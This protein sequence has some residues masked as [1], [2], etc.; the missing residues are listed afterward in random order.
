MPARMKQS[1]K[2]P[3]LIF[4]TVIATG[5]CAALILAALVFAL[6]PARAGVPSAS[7]DL[8]TNQTI[9]HLRIDVTPAAM[10]ALRGYA[11]QPDTPRADR[12]EV[13]CTVREGSNVWTNVAIHLKGSLG[14]FRPV[15]AKPSFTL[16]F[17]KHDPSQLFH[18]LE[19]ISL[20]NS[21]QDP[22]RLSEKVARELY[23]RGGVPVPRAGHVTA[24]WNGRA[25]G[26]YV[27]LEGWDRRFIRRYF[28]DARGPLQEGRL[29]T[30]IDQPL[31]LAFGEP[32]EGRVSIAALL[33]A[34][35]EP[36]A[37]KRRTRLDS[38]LDLDRFTRLLALDILAWNGDGYAFHANNYRVFFDRSRERLVF[39][40]HGLD[41]T[42]ILPDAPVLASGDGLVATAVLSLPEGR[43][44]VLDRIREFRGSFFQPEAIS[45]RLSELAAPLAAAFARLTNAYEVT[46]VSDHAQAVRD[47]VQRM[48]ERLASIDQQLAGI[49]NLVPILEGQS[50]ALNGWNQ[51]TNSGSPVFLQLTNP[52]SLV[53][54][55]GTNI[56][57][58]WVT[59]VWLEGGRYRLEGRVRAIPAAPGATNH[60]TAGLRVRSSR[61]RSLGLDW[62][63]D[64]RRRAAH[65]PGSESGNLAYA[66]LPPAAGSNWT[67][68][69]CEI[70]LRQ[71]AADLEIFCEAA[72][73]GEAWFDR[74]S[75]KL[76]RLTDPG[77]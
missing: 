19:K 73:A 2:M 1:L 51:R 68:L 20:N 13:L 52:A 45:N 15:D 40:P 57:G 50:R 56:S 7:D 30:D 39:M 65:H 22:T 17:S 9:R 41:Q 16:N 12:P 36:D 72:G 31:D 58:A 59:L 33:A 26:L 53:V 10:E 21:A 55:T 27:L 28:P 54:R 74:A 8:F 47:L 18:G 42:Y 14:S 48:T 75:L 63:W 6:P 69:A 70:D 24:E 67:E 71:P 46:P 11:F 44:Q 61:K 76:T 38:M 43:R 4:A 60:I 49:T 64:G 29:L 23:V 25:L 66:A 62:G 5:R 32:L 3:G 37:A 77:R 35:R 34:A